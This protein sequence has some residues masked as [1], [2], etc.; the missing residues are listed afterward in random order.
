MNGLASFGKSPDVIAPES[1]PFEALATDLTIAHILHNLV[2]PRHA[3]ANV[4]GTGVD[5]EDE[6]EALE[7][8]SGRSGAGRVAM[9][10]P[11]VNALAREKE[12][13]EA[14]LAF[15]WGG[16]QLVEN[17][18][19]HPHHKPRGA[20]AFHQTGAAAGT[21]IGHVNAFD[22]LLDKIMTA[23]TAHRA[24]AFSEKSLHSAHSGDPGRARSRIE[25][26]HPDMLS[27]QQ[28]ER[29]PSG[30]ANRRFANHYMRSRL[31]LNTE[32]PV[33]LGG[34]NKKTDDVHLPPAVD[35]Y[36]VNDWNSPYVED[37]VHVAC[38]KDDPT[39]KPPEEASQSKRASLRQG[40]KAKTAAEVVNEFQAESARHDQLNKKKP[41][42]SSRAYEWQ[43]PPACEKDAAE[44]R[45]EEARAAK[46]FRPGAATGPLIAG[47]FVSATRDF[48]TRGDGRG[49]TGWRFRTDHIA[50]KMESKGQTYRPAAL[51]EVFK[52]EVEQ[53]R[54]DYG[55]WSCGPQ[56]RPVPLVREPD[57]LGSGPGR[58]Y[59]TDIGEECDGGDAMEHAKMRKSLHQLPDVRK[60][61]RG[62]VRKLR[63]I[64]A[65]ISAHTRLKLLQIL[66]SL[67]RQ[68]NFILEVWG[69]DVGGDGETT[70]RELEKVITAAC[71]LRS[72][73]LFVELWGLI[74]EVRLYGNDRLRAMCHAGRNIL[75]HENQTKQLD[76]F[77][78]LLQQ[79]EDHAGGAEASSASNAR[80]AGAVTDFF[81]D[82]EEVQEYAAKVADWKRRADQADSDGA[83]GHEVGHETGT[84]SSSWEQFLP[85][86]PKP[87]R[88]GRRVNV[89]TNS[90]VAGVCDI[91]TADLLNKMVRGVARESLAA[92]RSNLLEEHQ[93]ASATAASANYSDPTLQA[94]IRALWINLVEHKPEVQTSLLPS[95][96]NVA[97]RLLDD[98]VLKMT[99]GSTGHDFGSRKHAIGLKAPR[100][101]TFRVLLKAYAQC[102][103]RHSLN[104]SKPLQF[105]DHY[106]EGDQDFE[107][108]L[109]VEYALPRHLDALAGSSSGLRHP[110]Q[111]LMEAATR[112]CSG[113]VYNSSLKS[114][115]V[116]FHLVTLLEREAA[117]LPRLAS[118]VEA[119]HPP[120]PEVS[121][122][123]GPGEET[124]SSDE[125]AWRRPLIPPMDVGAEILSQNLALKD[126]LKEHEDTGV[127]IFGEGKLVWRF[128]TSLLRR[129]QSSSTV[130]VEDDLVDLP[131]DFVAFVRPREDHDRHGDGTRT[132]GRAH[133]RPGFTQPQHEE[134]EAEQ[135]ASVDDPLSSHQISLADFAWRTLE[136]LIEK[137]YAPTEEVWIFLQKSFADAQDP[138]YGWNKMMSLRGGPDDE[139]HNGSGS[140][141]QAEPATGAAGCS[142]ADENRRRRGGGREAGEV[143]W[144]KMSLSS[145]P[146]TSCKTGGAKT[147]LKTH[148]FMNAGHL[149]WEK[150]RVLRF[151]PRA[152]ALIREVLATQAKQGRCKA[153]LG[154]SL[155]QGRFS[156]SSYPV[157]MLAHEIF[158]KALVPR[159]A[160]KN[161]DLEVPMTNETGRL[162][163]V[164][165]LAVEEDEPGKLEIIEL[166]EHLHD[167]YEAARN[168][169][170][171]MQSAS[172]VVEND[173]TE[174][175]EDSMESL[176]ALLGARNHSDARERLRQLQAA[177]KQTLDLLTVELMSLGI[178][179]AVRQ[180]EAGK[181]QQE[182]ES[183]AGGDSESKSV[184]SSADELKLA[185]RVRILSR[186]IFPEQSRGEE[187]EVDTVLDKIVIFVNTELTRRLQYNNG[188]GA[189]GAILQPLSS[190]AEKI[191]GGGATGPAAEN[192]SGLASPIAFRYLAAAGFDYLAC[193]AIDEARVQD[194]RMKLAFPTSSTATKDMDLVLLGVQLSR[195][196][197]QISPKY[198]FFPIVLD[199][200]LA[201]DL[202]AFASNS[203]MGNGYGNEIMLEVDMQEFLGNLRSAV[204]RV[205]RKGKGVTSFLA[206]TVDRDFD[207]MIHRERG[208]VRDHFLKSVCKPIDEAGVVPLPPEV[209]ALLLGFEVAAPKVETDR[210][211]EQEQ[212][213]EQEAEQE[214][215]QEEE[216]EDEQTEEQESE[217]EAEREA[218]QEAEQEA[219][220]QETDRQESNLD[221]PGRSTGSASE[222]PGQVL[223]ARL[224]E[225]L[226]V[227]VQRDG[228]ARKRAPELRELIDGV[229]DWKDNAV[230]TRIE[231]ARKAVQE[232]ESEVRATKKRLDE[233]C[234]IKERASHVRKVRDELREAV[235]V[236]KLLLVNKA[237]ELKESIQVD[238]ILPLTKYY[239]DW[240]GKS[241]PRP[242]GLVKRPGRVRDQ[243]ESHDVL[244]F[245]QL[246]TTEE[247]DGRNLAPQSERTGGP[248][249]PA[250]Q[251][252]SFERE[253]ERN[254][255][256]LSPERLEKIRKELNNILTTVTGGLKTAQKALLAK[257]LPSTRE[258]FSNRAPGGTAEATRNRA[259]ERQS[260]DKELDEAVFKAT[261]AQKQTLNWLA[262]QQV[263]QKAKAQLAAANMRGLSNIQYPVEQPSVGARNPTNWCWINSIAQAL[264]FAPPFVSQM[265]QHCRGGGGTGKKEN[266]LCAMVREFGPPLSM[267]SDLPSPM[268]VLKKETVS[269]HNVEGVCKVVG[270]VPQNE[271]TVESRED[272]GLYVVRDG[273]GN[274]WGVPLTSIESSATSVFEPT[275]EWK[276]VPKGAAIPLE[277]VESNIDWATGVT[278]ARFMPGVAPRGPATKTVSYELHS[279]VLHSGP[280]VHSGHYT[281]LVR[282]PR[283][284]NRGDCGHQG[285][286]SNDCWM[287]FDDSEPPSPTR[288]PFGGNLNEFLRRLLQLLYIGLNRF[289][290]GEQKLKN[291]VDIPEALHF[292]VD[293]T[294]NEKSMLVR[295]VSGGDDRIAASQ[296]SSHEYLSYAS[297]PPMSSVPGQMRALQDE[298]VSVHKVG[299]CRLMGYVQQRKGTPVESGE[300]GGLYVVRDGKAKFWGVPLRSIETKFEFELTAEWQKVPEGMSIPAGAEVKLDLESRVPMARLMP[301]STGKGATVVRGR[302]QGIR[303]A[304]TKTEKY[305]L[306]SIVL[307]S[308]PTV[309]AGH[310]TAL[311]RVP[312]PQNHRDCGPLGRNS[313]GCWMLFDDSKPPAPKLPLGGNLNEF[314]LRGQL[315]TDT[316]PYLLFY[317]KIDGNHVQAEADAKSKAVA[318]EREKVL[319]TSVNDTMVRKAESADDDVRL[320]D[321]KR[322]YVSHENRLAS[323]IEDSE[324][325]ESTIRNAETFLEGALLQHQKAERGE[326]QF[327]R[328]HPG[329]DQ[330]IALRQ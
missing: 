261:G 155:S 178:E 80:G 239:R 16:Q 250:R 89:E 151:A 182:A 49:N 137:G 298:L 262:P 174:D 92:A 185:K 11:R 220:E 204:N 216:Q 179:E 48:Y 275:A 132:G 40:A 289:T 211:T 105:S 27:E 272:G 201:R 9:R 82:K 173:E 162:S 286:N 235:R 31:Q 213:T 281:A 330:K 277:G 215:E 29:L 130:R 68:D 85:P 327:A 190:S 255:A 316:H 274:L 168:R 270:Y 302:G 195:E 280:T 115:D 52:T 186:A 55:N 37:D 141:E 65:R 218:E 144:Q 321:A 128:L 322:Q 91:N 177:Q 134:P 104:I 53:L 71:R 232:T 158:S 93:E 257:Q 70:K 94:T 66:R 39:W 198:F 19:E 45:A 264:F 245:L 25:I 224:K 187:V 111:V 96:E 188:R 102:L 88:L 114:G 189:G 30:A 167:G 217:R 119:A 243:A 253:L 175:P 69:S 121:A 244:E 100:D 208:A 317:V 127:K 18:K 299:M 237:K 314:L 176:R 146:Q 269:V 5:G 205:D 291:H 191:S 108:S 254:E 12:A 3:R 47:S 293:D 126:P 152:W 227:L 210:E 278:F 285:R 307:H 199:F 225:L 301:G 120:G 63:N 276:E 8:V 14:P 242:G 234:A 222:D 76:I 140:S 72:V 251:I 43:L 313:N 99:P 241:E 13:L 206:S 319:K 221:K 181:L 207:N 95:M 38:E 21:G 223:V 326:D 305:E 233:L 183:H 61:E 136:H 164:W 311:V 83:E 292:E 23:L 229:R 57:H 265:Q 150:V 28:G 142:V 192:M 103:T 154:H 197:Q 230:A 84:S 166:L 86:R 282:V 260:F 4:D 145:H 7:S 58:A 303:A 312:R 315:H 67:F 50:R 149:P 287:V 133:T 147:A 10:L 252:S 81:F 212:K 203:G 184:P 259:A 325:A 46:A 34:N 271:G 226:V 33:A 1:L 20:G 62:H 107:S 300:D 283:S 202:H 131:K 139:E 231:T 273:R 249:P 324:L 296:Y 159:L 15:P 75:E 248:A 60:H 228:S 129:F 172:N 304:A 36:A 35:K 90:V 170:Q 209:R 200:I 329:T 112:N 110:L 123:G 73:Q 318:A 78:K 258:I 256:A 148:I 101:P 297:K 54:N 268:Q 2:D 117:K 153:A 309:H 169:S 267:K 125:N 109:N 295:N 266:P 24:S 26:G 284:Q 74:S 320:A 240:D 22:C 163:P 310:Y 238:V 17:S 44:T 306:H 236:L 214:Q 42:M 32:L 160:L 328:R 118:Y 6:P 64:G 246:T 156:C 288:V 51:Y 77:L 97:W 116:S 124:H 87:L 194:Q 98:R 59:Y 290:F 247:Q 122:Q 196:Q 56:K 180:I 193:E 157:Y 79:T 165:E 135:Q 41:R 113:G 279:I 161:F 308:G 219:A 171:A 263:V 294:R 143:S 138:S 323:A 106:A